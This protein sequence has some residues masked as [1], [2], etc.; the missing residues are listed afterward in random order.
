MQY[1]LAY[2]KKKTEH[3]VL[4][5]PCLHMLKCTVKI[6]KKTKSAATEHTKDL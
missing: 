2:S 6:D 1:F 3:T 5:L 4:L